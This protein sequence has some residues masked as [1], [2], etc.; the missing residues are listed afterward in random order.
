MA[1]VICFIRS[2]PIHFNP[3]TP[4]GGDSKST[5]IPCEALQQGGNTK[6]GLH[7]ML[8]SIGVRLIQQFSGAFQQ[9]W[10]YLT[11]AGNPSQLRFAGL[12]VQLDDSC[13][14]PSPAP[15]L[16]PRKNG[17][18]PLRPAVADGS[19]RVPAC[20]GPPES[21]FRHPFGPPRPETPVSTSSNTS[22]AMDSCSAST[23]F[24]ASMI[25]ANSPPEAILA[26]GRRSSPALADIRNRIT[27][28]PSA[29]GSFP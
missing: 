6:T 5:Q 16:F 17:C 12:P 3:H 2:A 8:L 26:M 9:R 27:S 11:A 22:V 14:R 21:A 7:K 1:S 28:Q 20:A 4:R 24:K 19:R 13:E 25:R 29:A 23:F 10:R 15:P 18:L